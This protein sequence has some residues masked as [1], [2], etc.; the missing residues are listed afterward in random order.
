MGTFARIL[1]GLLVPFWIWIAVLV[2]QTWHTGIPLTGADAFVLVSGAST[3]AFKFAV[4][5]LS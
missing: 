2:V 3:L 5:A 4:D 1:A